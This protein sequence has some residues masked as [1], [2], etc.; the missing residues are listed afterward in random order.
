[1]LGVQDLSWLSMKKF[2]GNRGAKDDILNYD[3]RRIDAE[4][5]KNVMKLIKKRSSSFE[6]ENIKRVS[7]A[8]A[9]MA[10]W[11]LANIRYSTVLEKIQP[12]ERDLEE[13]VYQLEQSQNRL[14]MRGGAP[15]DR[16][17][18]KPAQGGIW[19][20]YSRGRATEKESCDCW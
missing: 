8:A 15:G 7:V 19:R 18:G 17:K 4:L 9:P 5:R 13:Q 11:V 2:L 6:A 10:A 16:R 20:P 3:T 14:K 12:L 1:M